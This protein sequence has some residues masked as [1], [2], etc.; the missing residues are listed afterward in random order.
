MFQNFT[1]ATRPEDGPPRLMALRAHLAAAGLDG[2]LVPRAD[3][4]QGE[5]VA[6]RDERLAW[7]TGFTGSAGF[8]AVLPDVA[9]VFVDGRYRVQVKA[10]VAD[11]FTPVDWPEEPLEDWLIAALPL[12]GV[13]GFDPWLHT[14]TEVAR[15]QAALG[16][17]RISLRPVANAVDVIW[18]DQP[19]RPEGAA[20]AYPEALAGVSSADKRALVAQALQ[21]ADETAAVLSLPDSINWLLNIRGRDLSHLPVVQAFAIVG[22]D[23]AVSVF[24]DPTKFDAVALADGVSIHEWAAFEGALQGLSGLVR[25]DSASAPDA[26]R[27]ILEDAGVEVSDGADP[28]LLPKARKSPAEIAATSR[29]HLRDAVAIASA[30]KTTTP[31]VVK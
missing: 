19:G 28:C 12:G 13:V 1:A 11:V 20:M 31:E 5:Y 18:A 2:F 16:P 29:A 26:V 27:Q 30:A 14:R 25:V 9:G 17:R 15:L 7:L 10:Q 22:A 23:R 24:C 6:P 4:H 3:A 21:T 8:A